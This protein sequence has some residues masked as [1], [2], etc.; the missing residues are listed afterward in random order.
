MI[1]LICH[2]KLPSNKFCIVE[3]EITAKLSEF[4]IE[5]CD[6]KGREFLVTEQVKRSLMLKT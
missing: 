5:F 1:K 3:S 6:K 2:I 4:K